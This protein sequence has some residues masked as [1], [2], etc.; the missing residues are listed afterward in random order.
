MGDTRFVDTHEGWEGE[1]WG[2]Y[3]DALGMPLVAA[4]V[5]GVAL[6]W[7]L[8]RM[9]A[10]KGAG[11]NT[12]RLELLDRFGLLAAIF[13][14]T[15]LALAHASVVDDAFI[16][17]R[18][19][20]HLAHGE[21]LVFNAGEHVEGYT[22][23]LWT[24]IIGVGTFVTRIPPEY[25]GLWGALLA[26]VLHLWMAQR[27]ARLLAGGATLPLVPLLLAVQY[28]FNSFG[29]TGLETGFTS[30]LV[31]SGLYYLVRLASARDA[32]YAGLLLILAVLSRPDHAVFYAAG[33]AVVARAWLFPG[34]TDEKRNLR[35]FLLARLRDREGRT[36]TLAYAAPFSL[37]VA[38]TA[39]RLLY[40]GDFFPNTYY[41]KS[42]SEPWYEQG[43]V[44]AATFYVASHLWVLLLPVL[45][46][47]VAPA[48]SKA[49]GRFKLF[50]LLSIVAFNVYV[51]RVG[52]D[53]MFGRFYVTLI[54]LLLLSAAQAIRE[55]ADSPR[56]STRLAASALVVM[57]VGTVGGIRIIA[58]GEILFGI[59][60][61]RTYYPVVDFRTVSIPHTSWNVGRLL[62]ELREHGQR[63][64]VAT[65]GVGMLGY[66]SDLPVIDLVGLTDY[67]VA[68][69]KLHRRGRP[70]HE[71]E[72]TRR[73]IESRSPN[74]VRKMYHPRKYAAL[75]AVYLDNTRSRTKWYIYRYDREV[76]RALAAMDKGVRFVDF[77][78]YARRYHKQIWH[79]DRDEAAE[80]LHFFRRYF[81][82]H[83]DAEGRWK[84]LVRIFRRRWPDAVA[85]TLQ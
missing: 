33:A 52:G 21:G 22:N 42:A 77:E 4:V 78:S 75:T 48:S 76:M 6:A 64:I 82:D 53:F 40:Y 1:L 50:S 61:E 26:F 24:V 56:R 84:K 54:P 12:R 55:L 85:T 73:Y 29:T 69:Q 27:L 31:I 70:G 15:W 51:M 34:A 74:F 13:G 18:Y 43:V 23:F 49:V 39:F 80:D 20:Q 8:T 79:K 16:S 5:A 47:L 9:P 3:V 10:A 65:S 30:L 11:A 41:A 19:S 37:Y 36:R 68:H 58:P 59:A 7:L 17:F 67:H 35:G 83:N 32:G 38:H 25:L 62:G 57:V 45:L 63:P 60:D 66:Y 28:T 2:R 81:F 44:Y 46:W 72:A 14:G 71:K